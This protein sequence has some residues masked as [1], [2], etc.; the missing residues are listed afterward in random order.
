MAGK[1]KYRVTGPRGGKYLTSTRKEAEKLTR[2][3]GTIR[4]LGQKKASKVKNPRKHDYSVV[5]AKIKTANRWAGKYNR[6][7]KAAFAKYGNGNGQTISGVVRDHFPSSVK[8]ELR[9]LMRGFN[10]AQDAVG[11][12]WHAVH[13]RT[14]FYRAAKAAPFRDKMT[15]AGYY[16]TGR[17]KRRNPGI[18][19]LWGEVGTLV[20]FKDLKVG[21]RFRVPHSSALLEKV[22]DS[23]YIYIPME[24]GDQVR[25]WHLPLKEVIRVD[26]RRRNPAADKKWHG[27]GPGSLESVKWKWR[28]HRGVDEGW[29]GSSQIEY[30]GSYTVHGQFG[31][32]DVGV[33]GTI[34]FPS[35]PH[36]VS[37]DEI[38]DAITE[39]IGHTLS[40]GGWE[41]DWWFEGG[42]DFDPS[43]VT[44][45][46]DAFYDDED[47][48]AVVTIYTQTPHANEVKD[49][50]QSV[51][52][53]MLEQDGDMVYAVVM[54]HD[55]RAAVEE[56]VGHGYA[57][58]EEY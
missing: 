25:D 42:G 14:D 4:A 2:H 38:F 21:D 39:S 24:A 18:E 3:G 26:G 49:E 27:F 33:S 58:D 40:E 45:Y 8:D 9:R 19:I 16:G 20:R 54:T 36:R 29:T 15:Q 12:A 34:N 17:R 47:P 23:G 5:L 28:K 51:A 48:E 41:P 50:V 30:Y 43:D 56:L 44:W 11:A 57:V 55:L 10:N 32:T 13:P 37:E 1:Y 53:S 35:A 7:V 22:G 46:Y 52:G 6:A 31:E